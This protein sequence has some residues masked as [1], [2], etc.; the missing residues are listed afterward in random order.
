MAL[1]EEKI[2][3]PKYQP[4]NR[5]R[6]GN[7]AIHDLLTKIQSNEDKGPNGCVIDKIT[8]KRHGCRPGGVGYPDQCS[9][10]IAKWLNS[11]DW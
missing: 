3:L 6:V 10:C 2:K 8:G 11:T 7:M 9:Q 4:T 1:E 5:I